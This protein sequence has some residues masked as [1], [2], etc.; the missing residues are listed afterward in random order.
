MVFFFKPQ[1]DA[2][3]CTTH[4]I[5]S[6]KAKLCALAMDLFVLELVVKL[7]VMYTLPVGKPIVLGVPWLQLLHTENTGIAFSAGAALPMWMISTLTGLLLLVIT[8]Y[9]YRTLPLHTPLQITS[10]ALLLAGGWN[11]WADRTV[12]GAVTDYLA[13][14]HFPVFNLADVFVTSGCTL[15]LWCTVF[16]PAKQL[17]M[18]AETTDTLPATFVDH[19]NKTIFCASETAQQHH[20][21]VD[22]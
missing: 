11:N 18:G 7:V 21:T 17:A 19:A 10:V 5:A 6:A 16:F 15:L 9:S 4:K 2:N 8:L 14:G 12:T 13:V 1:T 3:T 22:G 20:H